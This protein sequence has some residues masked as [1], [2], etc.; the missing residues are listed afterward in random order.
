MRRGLML[1]AS[2]VAI[3][4]AA[5]AAEDK[6]PF[7]FERVGEAPGTTA[8]LVTKAQSFLAERQGSAKVATQQVDKEAGR[9]V[10][11]IVLMNSDAGMFD[12]FHGVSTRLILEFKEGR[13]R[14]RATDIWG[15]DRDGKRSSWGDVNGANRYRI[16]PLAQAV[17]DRFA[18]D[19]DAYLKRPMDN[20]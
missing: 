11:D 10:N 4:G 5:H 8:Q 2:L 19:L 12:A 16:E 20:W 9:I 6:P 13:Y 3:L 14:L 7:Q 1:A 15:A 18:A 17:L